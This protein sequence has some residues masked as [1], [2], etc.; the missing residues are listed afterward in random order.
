MKMKKLLALLLALAMCASLAACGGGDDDTPEPDESS[1]AV[2][3]PADSS[4][5]DA[6]EPADVST[7]AGGEGDSYLNYSCLEGIDLYEVLPMERLTA[8]AWEATGGRMDGNDMEAEEFEVFL[9][10][11][12]NKLQIEFLNEESANFTGGAGTVPGTF[13]VLDDGITMNL[14]FDADGESDDYVAVFT[15]VGE[16]EEPMMVLVSTVSPEVAFYLTPVA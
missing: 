16:N 15:A 8:A 12:G 14:S 3:E 11:F 13:R 7:P 5:G 10:L 2:S 6:S 9:E 1:G 4:G